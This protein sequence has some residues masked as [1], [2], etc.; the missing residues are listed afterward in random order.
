MTKNKKILPI[1]ISVSVLMV[2]SGC[3]GTPGGLAPSFNDSGFNP[4][5]PNSMIVKARAEIPLRVG[6]NNSGTPVQLFGGQNIEF[7][8]SVIVS[9]STEFDVDPSNFYIPGEPYDG[10]LDFG[11]FGVNRLRDNDLHGCGSPSAR[12]S[13][14]G[15]RVYTKDAPGAGFW[16][17]T[18]NYGLPILTSG[19]VVGLGA[20]NAA[21]VSLVNIGNTMHI[22]K[23][24]HFTQT[25]CSQST[26]QFPVPISVDFSDAAAGSYSTTLVIEYFLQ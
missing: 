4:I 7:P 26:A 3:I 21:V 18:D 19:N 25:S 5:D 2:I 20:S 10:V 8:V 6:S 24:C 12:C 22:I 14:A 9:P 11:F 17:S 23:L 16:H 1:L 13:K 15:I